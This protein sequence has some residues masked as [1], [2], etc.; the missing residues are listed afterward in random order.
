MHAVS[1]LSHWGDLLVAG[2]VLEMAWLGAKMGLFRGVVLGM[3]SMAACIVALAVSGRMAVWLAKH[4]A[5]PPTT[6]LGV[7]FLA[8]LAVASIGMQYALRSLIAE[9]EVSL[10]P[11]INKI[12]GG[13]GGGLA[14][15]SFAGAILIAWSMLPIPAA[16]RIDT[17]RMALDAGAKILNTF[18]RCLEIEPLA[19]ER[20]L[21]TYRLAAWNRPKEPAMPEPMPEPEPEPEPESMSEK[22]AQNG[23]M[24]P[25]IAF[26]WGFIPVKGLSHWKGE[27]GD[28]CD[29]EVPKDIRSTKGKDKGIR[30]KG[31][32]RLTLL[33]PIPNNVE[34]SFKMRV[35]ESGKG[36][37]MRP[38]VFLKGTDADVWLGNDGVGHT[39]V[40][41]GNIQP[42]R[43]TSRLRY[44]FNE[45]YDVSLSLVEQRATLRINA[46]E[47]SSATV[48]DPRDEAAD[49]LW[50]TLSSGDSFSPGEAEF[51][52]L[53]TSPPAAQAS[54]IDP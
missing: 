41:Q 33:Y 28:W 16:L 27:S 23:S 47:I 14:G 4:A 46:Q 18:A 11:M 13:L 10:P 34:V 54:T 48:T 12:G 49:G 7:V 35:R 50:L 6:A 17:T 3:Q 19:R 8:I 20:L 32:S 2:I 36:E 9:R 37:G 39:L 26:D 25:P 53:R 15:I 5:I 21:D 51:W 30:G 38:A 24:K 31:E 22:N 52:D 43:A 44:S 29:F 45:V 1:V 40:L 42:K